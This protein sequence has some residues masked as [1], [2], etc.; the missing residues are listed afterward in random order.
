VMQA[1]GVL[2]TRLTQRLVKPRCPVP[3]RLRTAS[4]V[5]ALLE[6]QIDA[7]RADKKAGNVLTRFVAFS[8]ISRSCSS[9][10]IVASA[11]S[12]LRGSC[13][14][15]SG[16]SA[17]S[18]QRSTSNFPRCSLCPLFDA[19][20][21]IRDV[22]GENPPPATVLEITFCPNLRAL[23]RGELPPKGCA[24]PVREPEDGAQA[25][26]AC[27]QFHHCRGRRVSG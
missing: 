20:R 11:D 10:S 18:R 12:S 24:V 7:V 2:L 27:L 15:S 26:G 9:A 5:L 23:L 16:T 4:D 21:A 17:S 22:L 14:L 25:E 6:E 3:F 13:F 19:E 8:M 1:M